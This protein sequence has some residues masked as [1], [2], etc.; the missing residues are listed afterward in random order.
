M[1][2]VPGQHLYKLAITQEGYNELSFAYRRAWMP[3]TDEF[4][5]LVLATK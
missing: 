1:V 2:G 4:T 5:T 3:A